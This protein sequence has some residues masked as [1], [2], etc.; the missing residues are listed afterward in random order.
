M[1][2]WA[3]ARHSVPPPG[4]SSLRSLW[5]S[6]TH[7]H[8]PVPVLLRTQAPHPR[9]WLRAHLSLPRSWP[10]GA[11][12]TLAMCC[13]V[14]YRFVITT[15]HR[16]PGLPA[17]EAR[18]QAALTSSLQPCPRGL[19]PHAAMSREKSL[20]TLARQ[21]RPAEAE[22]ALQ[23]WVLALTLPHPTRAHNKACGTGRGSQVPGG[24]LA[25]RLYEADPCREASLPRHRAAEIS[26][27]ASRMRKRGWGARV[28]ALASGGRPDL[29]HGGLSPAGL[30]LLP[31]PPLPPVSRETPCLWQ[32]GA[33]VEIRP[34]H[35]LVNKEP[36]GCLRGRTH[37]HSEKS[38]KRRLLSHWQEGQAGRAPLGLSCLRGT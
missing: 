22:P 21:H 1:L 7:P 29:Q 3:A 20:R 12:P 4:L 23:A 26:L 11:L 25:L 19:A 5:T 34:T 27:Q 13:R 33:R 2:V 14:C 10:S 32:E 6:P 24:G 8:S 38:W 16:C 9:H 37:C 28:W 17:N 18:P 15:A 35:R 30:P 31:L 36:G